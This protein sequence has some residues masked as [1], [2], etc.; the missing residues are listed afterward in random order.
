MIPVRRWPLF[1]VFVVALYVGRWMPW[2][3]WVLVLVGVFDVTACS[4]AGEWWAVAVSAGACAAGVW[5]SFPAERGSRALEREIRAL[6]DGARAA[7]N[8]DAS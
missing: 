4:L 1:A 5:V 3:R 2:A 7:G 6:R 8:G